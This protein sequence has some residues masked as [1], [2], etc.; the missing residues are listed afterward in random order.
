MG[1][2]SA[3]ELGVIELGS[4]P[5]DF[6]P[7]EPEGVAFHRAWQASGVT[8]FDCRYLAIFRNK[9]RIAVAPFF[10]GR[11]RASTMLPK[12]L[13]KT[14]FGWI[15]LSYACVGHPSTDF[16]VIDGQID[17]MADEKLSAEVLALVN[18]TLTKKAPLVAYKGFPENLP[19]AGFVKAQGLPVAV[20]TLKGDY[21]AMLNGHRRY[22][23]RHKL[24]A[25]S[26]LS[27]E[28]YGTLPAHLLPSV[29]RLYLDTLT[30]AEMRFET[31]TP[32]YFSAMAGVGK[33]HLYFEGERLIGFLQLLTQG[34]KANIKYIGV[35]HQRNRPYF[36]YFVMCI[37]AI[38]TAQRAG[39]TRIELGVSSYQAKHLMGCEQIPTSV[40]FRHRNPLANWL[41]GK[42]KLLIEP[43]RDELR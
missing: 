27:F 30:H 22:D 33:F 37:R 28:E 35:D 6:L 25:A 42:C 3:N 11:Y 18:A 10:T 21:F 29:F 26:A 8:A 31:L 14:L 9:K 34:E 41:L 43:G 32:E 5:D 23:Y 15:Q 39:C 24:Q 2:P 36:L 12:G 16:G 20:L 19:L 13:L 1:E 40:Y 4:P 7:D 38:E 17:G